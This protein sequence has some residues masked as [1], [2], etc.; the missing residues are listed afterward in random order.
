MF[1]FISDIFWIFVTILIIISGLY[2]SF[3]IKFQHF[4]FKK[5]LCFLKVKETNG[6]SPIQ[7]LTM[8]L[9]AKIGVGS[10]SGIAVAIYLGGAGTVFW[11]WITA[12]VATSTTFLESTYAVI[13]QKKDKNNIKKGGPWYYIQ[14]GLKNK[15]LASLYAAIIIFV[16]SFGFLTLQSNTIAV[17]LEEFNINPLFIGLFVA[18]LT[19]LIIINGVKSIAYTTEVLVPFM[20]I[21]YLIICLIIIFINIELIP[22]IFINIFKDAFNFKAAGF[23]FL[24]TMIIGMQKGVFSNEVGIGTGAIV[25]ATS[26]TKNPISQGYIQSLGIYVDTLIIGTLSALVVMCCDFSSLNISDVNGIEV[27]KYAF[28]HQLGNFGNILI[29]IIIF[30]FAFATIIT[31]YYYVE[32]SLKFFINKN[33]YVI[34][35]LKICTLILITLGSIL[36]SALLW[37]ITDFFIGVIAVINIYAI[38]KIKNRKPLSI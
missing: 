30:L 37:N 28:S 7:T 27:V 8:N 2:F 22:S 24:L 12:L 32:S 16:F 10:I 6:I 38:Y 11:M 18:F 36:S 35:V 21:L 3:K 5:I 29:T 19:G 26:N 23:G 4:N 31:G 33:K 13:Y 34:K 15:R 17:G 9:A 25:A 14:D 1:L 20:G